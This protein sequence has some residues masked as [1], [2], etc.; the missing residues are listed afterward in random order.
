MR[1]GEKF[2]DSPALMESSKPGF[3]PNSLQ[4]ARRDGDREG[5]VARPMT[6]GPQKTDGDA[7]KEGSQIKPTGI[8]ADTTN[9]FEVSGFSVSYEET[10]GQGLVS[11][12]ITDYFDD[13]ETAQASVNGDKYLM[14]RAGGGF[15]V[16]NIVSGAPKIT[17]QERELYEYMN[18]KNA[19]RR[20]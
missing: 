16:V 12:D 1:E 20:I 19:W 15:K 13:I 11:V 14:P 6:T 4:D 2:T 17:Y 18:T 10:K 3:D 5:G 7:A 8:P 9:K